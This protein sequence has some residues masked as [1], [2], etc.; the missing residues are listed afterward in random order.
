[1]LTI[2]VELWHVN[3][4]ASGFIIEMRVCMSLCYVLAVALIDLT[5]EPLE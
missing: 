2:S 5:V 1:M 3:F 4:P